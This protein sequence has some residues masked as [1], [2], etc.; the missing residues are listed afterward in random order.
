[1][2]HASR[3]GTILIGNLADELFAGYA[4]YDSVNNP[5]ALMQIDLEKALYEIDRL[6]DYANYEHKQLVAP[7]ASD[8]VVELAASVPL[9]RMIG[10]QG[11][12]LILRDAAREIGLAAHDRPKKAAQYSSGV[13]KAIKRMAKREG[14]TSRAWIESLDAG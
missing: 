12:K 11:R 4:K 5:A 3:E 10:P 8:R 14:L 6:V 13:A 7:F 1:V 2:I 9:S